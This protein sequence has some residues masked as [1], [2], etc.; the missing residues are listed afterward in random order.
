MKGV[1]RGRWALALLF[2]LAVPLLGSTIPITGL[3]DTGFNVVAGADQCYT[4][5]LDGSWGPVPASV[6]TSSYPL[7][8]GGWLANSGSSQWIAPR[9]N[10][11]GGV[12]DADGHYYFRT[13]FVLPDYV[14]PATAQITGFWSTDNEG[15][16]ILLN[17]VGTGNQIPF[18]TAPYLSFQALHAFTIGGLHIVG[19][20]AAVSAGFVKGLNT[21]DFE[22]N[23]PSGY[24]CCDATG[25]R[26]SGMQGTV[27]EEQIIPEPATLWLLGGGLAGLILLRR[28]R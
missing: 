15:L 6:V 10:Y 9:S 13:T 26:V 23:N 2:F 7:F 21:L 28:R 22:V 17:G 4:V 12:S 25:L 8:T 5:R 3:C 14:D 18:Y 16:D 20:G 11:S 1:C 27:D 19:L 24:P